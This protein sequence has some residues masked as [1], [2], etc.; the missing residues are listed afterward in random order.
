MMLLWQKHAIRTVWLT[1]INGRL[2]RA[3]LAGGHAGMPDF[4]RHPAT[5]VYAGTGLEPCNSKIFGNS[6][7]PAHQRRCDRSDRFS[8]RHYVAAAAPV[9]AHYVVI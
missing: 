5:F 6:V 9:L 3:R 2:P 1:G 7:Q 8:Q 4:E